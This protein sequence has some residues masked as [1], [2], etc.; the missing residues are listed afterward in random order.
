MDLL[1]REY[2]SPFLLLDEV[3][4]NGMLNNFL[5]T[6]SEKQEEK[7]RWDLFIHKLG[8]FDER[9]WDEFNRDLDRGKPREINKPSKENLEAT[10]KHS[11]DMMNHFEPTERG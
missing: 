8:A 9:T 4:K 5:D 7:T 3:I 10:V 11:F 6:F 2:A 1:F